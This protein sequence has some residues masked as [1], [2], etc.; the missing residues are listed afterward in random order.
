MRIAFTFN[1]QNTLSEAEAEFDTIET[2][3]SIIEALRRLGHAVYPIE[4][5]GA[6]PD[7]I[8]DLTD[9]RPNLVLNTAEG[10]HGRYREAFHPALF[11]RLGLPY[12][13]S[14][15]YVCS[16]TLDKALTK[17]VVAARGLP[18]AESVFARSV[19]DLG[20][21]R[22]SFPAI[23]KP[24]FEGSSK[25]ITAASVV[26]SRNELTRLARELLQ[27]YPDGIL[28]ERYISGTDVVVPFIEG[29]SPATGGVLEPASYRYHHEQGIYDF[30]MK[31]HGYGDLH[32]EVPADIPETVRRRVVELSRRAYDALGIRDLGRIDFRVSRDG[33]PYF[34]EVNALPSLEDGASIYSCGASV[35]VTGIDAVL[36]AV[37][38]SAARRYGMV[39][40]R[41]R[42]TVA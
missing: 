37:I 25:G 2:V 42:R 5:S 40:S 26:E 1:L 23:V 16:L 14:D 30:D 12:V 29:I 38:A 27:Q 20:Q 17:S 6:L 22:V 24:N 31:Q 28:V 32:I 34:L 15:P 3:E 9:A 18:V 21:A 8:S 13:G 4:V 35:G 41:A 7:V 10:S 11:E 39:A 36:E 19:A 33:T